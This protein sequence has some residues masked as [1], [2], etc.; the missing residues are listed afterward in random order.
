MN[1]H[2]TWAEETRPIICH[3]NAFLQRIKLEQP[4]DESL[5]PTKAD[6]LSAW[7]GLF[8]LGLIV[9][10]PTDGMEIFPEV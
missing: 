5:P 8:S 3:T 2:P 7:Q 4:S 6:I 9:P 1:T 10:S